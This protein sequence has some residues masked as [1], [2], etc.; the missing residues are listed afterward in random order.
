MAPVKSADV[1]IVGFG[2]VGAV[3]AGLLGRRGLEVVV[4]ERELDVYALP[5]AAHIDHTGLRA[6]Q[7]LGCLD[8]VLPEMIPNP[9]LDFVSERAEL[10][11]RLP[12]DRISISGL[13]S[14]MY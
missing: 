6:L 7:E 5:R 11:F 3:L 9:G 8:K 12:S 13:P 2:P 1:V 4:I 10:L 14:S